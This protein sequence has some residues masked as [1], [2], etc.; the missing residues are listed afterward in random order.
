[1]N[2]RLLAVASWRRS[3][4]AAWSPMSP[5]AAAAPPPSLRGAVQGRGGRRHV[6]L[7]LEQA[8][9]AALIA[10]IAVRRGMPARAATIALATAYQESNLRNLDYGDRD[11]LGLFQQRPSQG[12][13]TRAQILDPDHSINAF[14]DALEQVDGYGSCRSPRPPRRCSDPAFPERV[15]RPR[16]GR[17][18]AR[19]GA[20]RQLARR[21]LVHRRRRPR[22][23][24]RRPRRLR[25]DGA[26]RPPCGRPGAA[27]GDLPL[28]GFAPGGVDDGPHGGS[29]HYEGRADRRLRPAGLR[30]QQPP[31]LGDRQLPRRPGRPARHQHRDLRRPH[32]AAGAGS[33]EGWLD[34]RVPAVGQRRPRASSSTATTSTS[35]S[36]AD[37]SIPA[38]TSTALSDGASVERAHVV[39]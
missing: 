2:R 9:N 39:V 33:D 8:G 37:D 17:P 10:A 23:A 36:L 25:A 30:G 7:D 22:R 21:L 12:W 1:M 20:D 15:R 13:G 6:G 32:L 38:A 18:G 5:L 29:A 16:A 31:R 34:Y 35:T 19:L 28:G 3:A 26:G 27:F 14:Y 4:S 11:S 24:G